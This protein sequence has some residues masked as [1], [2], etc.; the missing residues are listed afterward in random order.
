MAARGRERGEWRIARQGV[1]G[2]SDP[3][4]VS[5]GALLYNIASVLT[6]L[7]GTLKIL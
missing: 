2:F 4:G 5:S 6:I 7:Y 3:R 1:Q